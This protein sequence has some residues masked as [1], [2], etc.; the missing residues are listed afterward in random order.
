MLI[1]KRT[2]GDL[3]VL[4][5]AEKRVDAAIAPDLKEY[6][7]ELA[8]QGATKV[9]LDLA[10][11]EFMDSSGLGAVV[12]GLKSMGGRGELAVCNVHGA[13]ADLFKLTRM[14]RVFTKYATVDEA[15]AAIG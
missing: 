3:I 13:V 4:D 11:V 1:N 8:K 9:L 12:A 2:K 5:V 6:I 10:A 7:A 14:D 15:M